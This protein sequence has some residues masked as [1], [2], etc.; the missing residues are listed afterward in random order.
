GT[1]PDALCRT[2][3]RGEC[4]RWPGRPALIGARGRSRTAGIRV[5]DGPASRPAAAFL[6][7][8]APLGGF[9]RTHA[10]FRV[11]RGGRVRRSACRGPCAPS[12]RWAR[13]PQNRV[14]AV[15][16]RSRAPTVTRVRRTIEPLAAAAAETRLRALLGR[17]APDLP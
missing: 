17:S 13:Y 12:G 6:C 5:T 9:S 2:V 15:S 10:T 14:L 4:A 1:G 8:A 7:R 3:R 16:C 11:V